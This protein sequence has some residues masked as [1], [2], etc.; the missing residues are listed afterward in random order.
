MILLNF[1]VKLKSISE[2]RSK[3]S[4]PPF[5]FFQSCINYSIMADSQQKSTKLNYA[6][7]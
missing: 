3:D 2:Q 7:E 1:K 4:Y 5:D 6:D